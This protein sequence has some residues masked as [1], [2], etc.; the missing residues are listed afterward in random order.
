MCAQAKYADIARLFGWEAFT[1]FYHARNL[2]F[3]AGL[4]YNTWRAGLA[5]SDARTLHLSIHAGCDLTPLI[6]FWGIH[7]VSS[8]Q[9]SA[10]MAANGLTHCLAVRCLLMRYRTCAKRRAHPT[11]A[12][13][14][15]SW[16]PA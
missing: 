16:L 9:L 13:A 1:S 4:T 15:W 6:H 12:L 7:P 3:E 14:A 10:Q 11:N 2:G 8:G 5:G